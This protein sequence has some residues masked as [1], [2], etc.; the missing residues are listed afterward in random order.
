M[1]IDN[2]EI[3]ARNWC[4][5]SPIVRRSDLGW[6]DSDYEDA[7]THNPKGVFDFYWKHCFSMVFYYPL[8]NN[9]YELFMEG[10]P[11]KFWRVNKKNDWN[12]EWICEQISWNE[13]EE[14]E[15][16]FTFDDDTDLWKLIKINGKPIG[17]VLAESLIVEIN[18]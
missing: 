1:E 16:L 15:V 9:F 6:H 2:A 13:H 12:G 14:G 7:E 4:S 8:E 18:Y 17:D 10:E 5:T 11:F 3:I